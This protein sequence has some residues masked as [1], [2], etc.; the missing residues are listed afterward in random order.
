MYLVFLHCR[1]ST[2]VNDPDKTSKVYI[3]MTNDSELDMSALK[4][5]YFVHHFKAAPPHTDDTD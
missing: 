5:V 3:N 4:S 1:I 2:L